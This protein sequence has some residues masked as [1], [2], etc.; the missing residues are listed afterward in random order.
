MVRL[1]VRHQVSDFAHWKQAY[2]AFDGERQQ[3]GVVGQAAYQAADDP[4]DVTAWHD[5]DNLEAAQ[6]F[7]GSTRLRAVMEAA[8]VASEPQVWFG[9]PA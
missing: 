3:M 9:I 4:N 7:A 2:D 6:A 1:F 5:F 8:G